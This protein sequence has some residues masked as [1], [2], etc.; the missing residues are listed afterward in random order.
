M[1]QMTGEKLIKE[2]LSIRSD[3]PII[4]CTGFSEKI[5][6]E[7]AAAIGAVEYIEKPVDK[8]DFALKVRRVLD[9]KNG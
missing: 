6:E 5:D 3:I 7:K 4:L 8:R 2:V 9:G 1:P